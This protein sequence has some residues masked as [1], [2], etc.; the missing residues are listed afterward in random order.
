[1]NKRKRHGT[2]AND[3]PPIISVMSRETGEQ[4]FWVCDYADKHTCSGLIAEDVQLH[5]AILYT[6]AW[7]SYHSS[8]QV[9]AAL[10]HA[11]HEWTRDEDK[12]GRRGV[13]CNTCEGAG[14]AL[15]P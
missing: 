1:V 6:D 10:C 15:R 2:H 8:H 13:H 5:S 3:R 7:Q 14:A 11:V 9:H 12:D 4:R